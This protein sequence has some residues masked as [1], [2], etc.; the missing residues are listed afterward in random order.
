MSLMVPLEVETA[1]ALPVLEA[2]AMDYAS[3]GQAVPSRSMDQVAY[4]REQDTQGFIA[5]GHE[6]LLQHSSIRSGLAV[7]EPLESADRK[8]LI[9]RALA[10]RTDVYDIT[11]DNYHNFALAAGVFVHNSAKQ[12]RD[13]RFQAILP[14]R[15]K[16][17]NVEKSRL[18]KALANKEIQA[19]ITALGTGIG[20]SFNLENLRYGRILIMSVDG[21][22][23]TFVKDPEGQVCAVRVGPFLSLIHI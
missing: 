12:G 22:E 4:Q 21:D 14:L 20:D 5:F 6:R 16:I 10:G 19:L 8:V 11:V 23:M 1:L 9:V 7:Y 15:G 3:I 18:D 17:L 13:R 2:R